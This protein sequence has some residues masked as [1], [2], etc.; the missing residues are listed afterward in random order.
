MIITI[1]NENLRFGVRVGAII[2]NKDFSKIFL[3]KQEKYDFYMFPGGRLEINEDTKTA[4]KRELEEELGIKEDLK[5]K[6]ICESFIKF[7]KSNY[8]EIGFYYITNIDESKY[9]YDK[10][11]K[12]N[13]L[14]EENDGKSTFEW[15]PI[16][17]L[18]DIKINLDYLKEKIYDNDS[19]FNDKIENIIYREY[20]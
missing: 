13:S 2:F 16:N 19:I 3:Q 1:K 11:V 7:P 8:H 17:E 14:D 5:L 20:K 12:Y 9:G 10:N 18:N 4:I 15:I 6:Y